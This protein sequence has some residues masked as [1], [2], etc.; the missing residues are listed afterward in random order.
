MRSYADKMV[1]FI[2]N[3][4]YF[5]AQDVIDITNTTCPHGVV[6]ELRK[7]YNIT[8]EYTSKNGKRFKIYKY[9]GL[10]NAN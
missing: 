6:Q 1:D 8:D 7:I 10:L 3:K 2:K 9:E 4:I 5:T